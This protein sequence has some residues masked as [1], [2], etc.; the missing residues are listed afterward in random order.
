MIDRFKK[1]K[2]NNELKQ[3]GANVIS[4]TALNGIT[5]IYPII[6]I[7]FLV[8]MLGVEK[9]GTY[10]FSFS[11]LQ[12]FIFFI[13]YGFDLSATKQLAI[14]KN[15]K[16]DVNKIFSTVMFLRLMFSTISI[17]ILFLLILFVPKIESESKLYI[18]GIG[19]F[20]GYGLL[21]LWF[22]M[23]MEKMKYVTIVNFISRIS[24]LFL[25]LLFI[26]KAEDYA[27]VNL[28]QSIGFVIGGIIS[29]WISIRTFNIKFT[30]PTR[31][32]IEFQLKDGWHLFLSA[33]GVNF[34]REANVILLGFLTNYLYVGYY[35]SAEKLV[36]AAQAVT[37]P[38][39]QSLFPF[40]GRKL[41]LKSE[42]AASL[43]KMNKI[44]FYYTVLLV[45]FSVII[46]V[47][48]PI[49]VYILGEEYKPAIPNLKIIAF[50]VTFG[51]LN[52]FYG[53]LGLVNLGKQK[54]FMKLILST[55]LLSVSLIFLLANR[56]NDLAA[57]IAL[58]SSE[59]FLFIL[60]YYNYHKVVRQQ[61]MPLTHL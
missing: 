31:S 50:V 2:D 7:P 12:Y 24:S 53:I 6:L 23:G 1:Y 39:C 59:L 55:G 35:A 14:C 34:F 9:Y 42:K 22:F 58:L 61:S 54:L 29:L 38:I 25:I 56:F 27:Y 60:I 11:I 57:S 30:L 18:Y 47:S 17:F 3:I 20:L 43:K 51:G 13:N 49:I 10:A 16:N 41:S 44:G 19:I 5:F 28:F 4:L 21:P 8:R 48:G 32:D 37:M 52:Y 15:D 46:F 36:K 26:R 33:I 45:I 40:L